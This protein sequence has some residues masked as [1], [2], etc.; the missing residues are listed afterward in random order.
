VRSV[1]GKRSRQPGDISGADFSH[2]DLSHKDFSQALARGTDFRGS[3]LDSARLDAADCRKANF[4][5]AS[6]RGLKARGA[7][8]Q[9]ALF[10]RA[11]LEGSIL[12]RADLSGADLREAN[13]IL[14]SLQE[15][16]FDG[17]VLEGAD[18]R[19]CRGLSSGQKESLRGRG[20]R[21]SFVLE[22]LCLLE[23]ALSFPYILITVAVILIGLVGG[24]LYYQSGFNRFSS[25][26]LREMLQKAKSS[27]KY[28]D[29]LAID[30]ELVRRF[31]RRGN[32]NAVFNRTF[33]MAQLQKKQGRT[34]AAVRTLESLF[35]RLLEEPEKA[36]G[37]RIELA[38]VYVRAEDWPRVIA[39]L[40]GLNPE[41][42]DPARFFESRMALALALREEKRFSEAVEIYEQLASRFKH[43]PGLVSQAAEELAATRRLMSEHNK[44]PS[45]KAPTGRGGG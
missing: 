45:Q 20:A 29:A 19:F 41:G 28:E 22:K 38:G 1:R 43:K 2:T 32:R 27:E 40:S 31:E 10:R 16:R 34:D 3:L 42:I 8:F 35:D 17:T 23:T 13:L 30:R 39:L 15:A 4:E 37:V 21:V 36:A 24:L 5:G 44:T 14:S 18:L 25:A 33:D 12:D 11:D 26:T 9:E 7:D 6:G